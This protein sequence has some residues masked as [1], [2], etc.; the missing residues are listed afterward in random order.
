[1]HELGLL[2]VVSY[3]SHKGIVVQNSNVIITGPK[4]TAGCSPVKMTGQ[5]K[6]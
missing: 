1:M 3:V 5:T 2:S 4:I 6:F